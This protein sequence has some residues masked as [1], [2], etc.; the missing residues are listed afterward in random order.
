MNRNLR[1]IPQ[2]TVLILLIL[3]LA[4]G[5]IAHGE[6]KN[7]SF[8]L[9]FTHVIATY[10]PSISVSDGSVE[11]GKST[12]VGISLSGKSMSISLEVSGVGT[13]SMDIDPLTEKSY[14]VPGLYYDYM[15]V[16]LGLTLTTKGTVEGQ[17]RVE[18]N[19]TLDKTSIAWT[20]SGTQSATLNTT[21]EAKEGQS[22]EVS[23]QDIKYT[24]YIGVKAEGDVLG[25]HVEITLIDYGRLGSISGSP[26]SVNGTYKVGYFDSFGFL[27]W[28]GVAGLGSASC[29][30]G[31][32][33]FKMRRKL[34]NIP[35]KMA[36]FRKTEAICPYCKTTNAPAAK[37]C[38]R[39]G[40]PL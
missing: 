37:F 11:P 14:P 9:D 2:V 21:S 16:K 4:L 1:V 29:F 38:R 18:G 26:S 23:V 25:Q 32:L 27:P 12:T 28:V 22:I 7:V 34:R 17:L 24:L 5:S 6:S 3:S 31:Y 36:G 19:G 33:Y 35:Q 40:K 20:G 10:T 30:V 13:A 8:V 39:C 15:L